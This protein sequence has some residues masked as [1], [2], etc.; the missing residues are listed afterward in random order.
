V[1]SA[2]DYIIGKC[3]ESAS[4]VSGEDRGKLADLIVSKRKIF[5]YGSGRSG[6]VGQLFSVRLVQLGLDVHFVGEMTTPIMCKDDLLI[7]VS[8]T[9]ETASVVKT[10]NIAGRIGS[11]VVCITADP[12]S[13]LAH[14]SDTVILLKTG[15][16]KPEFAPLGTVFELS[17]LMF[18]DSF[19]ADMMEKLGCS[20]DDMRSRHAIWV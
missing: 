17:A 10:A 19:V 8:N 3:G 18:F 14:A 5:I 20:E 11:H 12:N 4:S 13:K 16:I 2:L 7:L 6:L 1:D 15:K 9:G